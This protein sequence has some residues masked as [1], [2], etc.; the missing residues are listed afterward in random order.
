MDDNRVLIISPHQDDETIGCGGLIQKVTSSGGKVHIAVLT[1]VDT[2]V[3]FNKSNG[4]YQQYDGRL[5]EKEFKN[6]VH[7]LAHSPECVTWEYYFDGAYH[8]RLDKVCISDIINRIEQT[9]LQFRPNIL[10][11][12]SETW[13]QDHRITNQACMSVI[14]PHFYSGTVL[15]YEVIGENNSFVPN[16]Y[17]NLSEEEVQ[18]KTKA[19]ACYASQNQQK[20]HAVS[21]SSIYDKMKYR[22]KMIFKD[23]AEAFMVLRVTDNLLLFS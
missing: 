9:I 15:A 16:Y 8:H 1:S 18:R 17:L 22:G 7:T 13:D 6:A 4:N 20:L 10:L 21:A 19:F 14:R 12:P 5:R 23:F 3:K 2:G 11:L